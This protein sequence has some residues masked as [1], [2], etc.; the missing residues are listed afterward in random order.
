[1]FINNINPTLLHLGP[2]EIRWYGIMY[3]LGFLLTLWYV[4]K[5]SREKKLPLS[6][7]EIDQLMSWLVISMIIG[8]RLFAVFV[9][10]PDYYLANPL[11]IPQVWKGGLS[12]H[13]GLLGMILAGWYFCKRKKIKLLQLADVFIIPLS[14]ALA[15]GRIGNFTNSELYGPPTTLPWGVNFLNET[16]TLGNLVFRHPTMLYETAYSTII[17]CTLLLLS[18]KKPKEG[19]TFGTFL[20]LYSIFRT[21]TEILRV[22]ATILGPITVG[23]AL[24]IP[25]FLI[26]IYLL[27]RRLR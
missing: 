15:L 10:H 19:K 4:R 25:L 2:L 24:N 1:M 7:E 6:Y 18:K 3:V 16:D 14:L 9:W 11:E 22:P 17:F 21:L 13:G 26:G 20:I 23:Q 12:F 27:V 8:A 5:A